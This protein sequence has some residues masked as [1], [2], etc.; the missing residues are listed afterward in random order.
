[1]SKMHPYLVGTS[2]F[3]MHLSKGIL[4]AAKQPFIMSNRSLSVLT[5]AADYNGLPL[6]GYGRVNG[7]AVRDKPL[8]RRVVHLLAAALKKLCRKGVLGNDT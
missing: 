5:D 4:I 1:M 7:A 8:H 6:A 3:E 2:C